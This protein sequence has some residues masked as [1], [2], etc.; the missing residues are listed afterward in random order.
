M[1]GI[2]VRLWLLVL[3][4]GLLAAPPAVAEEP[5]SLGTFK[6]WDAFSFSEGGGKICY[7]VSAPLDS[8][9]DNVRRGDVYAMVTHRPG[10]EVRDEVSL[11]AGYAYKEGSDAEVTIGGDKFGLFTSGENA[12]T[13]EASDD[14][15]LVNAMIRGA[16][17]IVQ[18]TSNR[19]TLTTDTYSLTG[20]TAAH[21][22]IDVACNVK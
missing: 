1:L 18:G 11:I 15:A 8:K 3:S 7:M 10:D 12:W 13:R 20:F 9:P 2:F 22:A 21:E 6:D 17:M 4:A 5:K 14:K 16:T 19:G